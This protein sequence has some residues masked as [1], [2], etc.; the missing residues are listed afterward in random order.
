M[1]LAVALRVL[2]CALAVFS[3][4]LAPTASAQENGNGPAT[5]ALQY[6]ARPESRAAFR[7]Y[8]AG[9]GVA[10]LEAW[11]KNG[12]FK[13]YQLLFSSFVN[14]STW[15]A[16]ALL[17]F[18]HYADMEKWKHVER[19][20]PGG[21]PPEALALASPT[22]TYVMDLKWSGSSG[23]REPSS[24]IYFVIPYEFSS[25][26]EYKTYVEAYVIPQ[27]KGWL[28][29]GNTTAFWIYLNQ[30]ETGPPP[31]A[32]IVLEYKDLEQLALRR[33]TIS[34][35]RAGLA[36]DPAWKKI[37]DAKQEVRKEGEV[38]IADP[39]LKP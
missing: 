38:V 29:E 34:K 9:K 20:Q 4:G 27:M 10:Q 24:P 25:R 13:D 5:L 31:D 15:D 30:N 11:K 7:A 21:L 32:V 26:A 36:N 19:R 6:K 18:D 39:I 33:Q 1:R 22:A 3:P 16:M 2:G 23:G 8:L 28:Q 14:A 35:V 12:V 37:S 17:H